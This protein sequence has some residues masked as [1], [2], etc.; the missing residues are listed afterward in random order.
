[1]LEMEWDEACRQINECE[2]LYADSIRE[3]SELTLEIVVTEATPQRRM[4][5]PDGASSL[6][7]PIETDATC[8]S[9]KL[10]FDRRHMVSYTVLNES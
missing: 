4:V 2:Y 1:M 10:V 3:I 8:R 5:A 6:F 9:F 7:E